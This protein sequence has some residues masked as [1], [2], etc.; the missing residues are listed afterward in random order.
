MVNDVWGLQKD[1]DMADVVAEAGA[2]VVLMHHREK[3]DTSLDIMADMHSFLARSVE[4]ATN[5]GIARNHMIVDP[6]LG[7]GRSH[8]QSLTCLNRLNELGRWF[9]L[10]VLLGASRKRFI[11]HVLDAELSA[12]VIGTVAANMMGLARGAAI[13]RVHDVAEHVEAVKIMTAV[14]AAG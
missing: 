4:I 2:L 11:G 14:E 10:P 8:A 6:G 12:R 1:P 5:A 13:I 9:D 7:F 3:E